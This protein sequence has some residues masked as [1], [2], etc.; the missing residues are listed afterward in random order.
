MEQLPNLTDFVIVEYVLC[1]P[2]IGT[3]NLCDEDLDQLPKN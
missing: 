1:T 2:K 3:K